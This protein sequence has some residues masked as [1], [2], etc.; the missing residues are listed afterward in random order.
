MRGQRR[1][2]AVKISATVSSIFAILLQ[3]THVSGLSSGINTRRVWTMRRLATAH[4]RYRQ[5]EKR[6]Q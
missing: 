6:S 2:S 1:V 5:T 4:V 3:Q